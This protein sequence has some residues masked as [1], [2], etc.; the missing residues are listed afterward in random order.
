MFRITF[1]QKHSPTVQLEDNQRLQLKF[2]I[3]DDKAQAVTVHQAFVIFVHGATKQ[4]VAYVAEADAQTKQYTFDLVC[5]GVVIIV[6][7]SDFR[8]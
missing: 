7:N 8:I 5:Y 1:G 3:V 2:K 4:E 6:E